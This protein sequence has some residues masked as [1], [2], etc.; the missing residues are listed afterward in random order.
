[1]QQTL[2]KEDPTSA[3]N[4]AS[5]ERPHHPTSPSKLQSLEQCACYENHEPE[6]LH[7]MTVRGTA[8]HDVVESGEIPEDMTDED[9]TMAIERR[10]YIKERCEQL[11]EQYP[12]RLKMITEEY[13]PIDSKPNFDKNGQLFLGTTAGYLD[14]ALVYDNMKKAELHDWKFGNWA[15]E[16]A[17]NN[18][19]GMAYALGLCQRFPEI[20]EVE[21]FFHVP[22]VSATPNT[23]TF[24]RKF[25]EETVRPRIEAIVSRAVAARRTGDWAMAR[26][27]YPTCAFCA[28]IANCPAVGNTIQTVAQKYSDVTV[29]EDI[30]PLHTLSK[31]DQSAAMRLAHIVGAWGVAFKNRVKDRILEGKAKCP[32]D[33][34]LVSYQEREI[35]DPKKLETVV[36][37]F[38]T[39]KKWYE[40]KRELI[41]TLTKIEKALRLRTP[42][43]AKDK[44][45][46]KLSEA[47]LESGAVER[48][49][50]VA[51]LRAKRS[52][53]NVSKETN[54]KG[55]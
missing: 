5:T 3:L 28:H 20:E 6:T 11:L 24:S 33:F 4:N 46:E 19:Q 26:P 32:D 17:V 14:C 25:L 38:I 8:Q 43:G 50:P 49:Q 54:E 52:K 30:N 12:G 13:C 18:T 51:F 41:P 29:P 42:R 27:N 55:N 31:E 21:V 22:R 16:P 2:K 45:V 37:K 53:Q 23:H 10:N 44:A 9:A 48:T 7:E 1:M 15:V 40:L 39:K 35:K 47:L 36:S 34:I